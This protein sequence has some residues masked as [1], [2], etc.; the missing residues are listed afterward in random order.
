M[1]ELNSAEIERTAGGNEPD[2]VL[3]TVR[4]TAPPPRERTV[5]DEMA[6]RGIYDLNV[7]LY[8]PNGQPPLIYIG[9]GPEPDSIGTESGLEDAPCGSGYNPEDFPDGVSPE[10]LGRE[11][12]DA[13]NSILANVTAGQ[14]QEGLIAIYQTANGLVS[15]TLLL[16]PVGGGQ[17]PFNISTLVDSNLGTLVA[18]VHNHPSGSVQ[19]GPEDY[20]AL[21]SLT[22]FTS[23]GLVSP[24]LVLY[25]GV[26][27]QVA[28]PNGSIQGTS[29]YVF[30]DNAYNANGVQE[31]Q[32]VNEDGSSGCRIS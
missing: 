26:S 27:T 19:P 9:F 28:T 31:G 8:G 25:V 14:N 3:P 17:V 6:M 15:G 23:T 24:N 29:L 22:A 2:L 11:A 20:N 10:A 21:N 16:G 18:L 13:I 1:R 32:R 7:L 4:T 30:T 12:W 5:A